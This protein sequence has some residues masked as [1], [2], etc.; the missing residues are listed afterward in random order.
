M[1]LYQ[2]GVCNSCVECRVFWSTCSHLQA[3][4]RPGLQLLS[5]YP[6]GCRQPLH[7]LTCRC[8][9]ALAARVQATYNT[10]PEWPHKASAFILFP[11]VRAAC[12]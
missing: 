1:G 3:P 6:L 9:C 4:G 10:V 5:L 2:A 7:A 11:D 12:E 8:V